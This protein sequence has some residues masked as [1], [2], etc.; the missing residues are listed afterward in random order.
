MLA[1]MN[2]TNQFLIAMPTLGDPNFAQTVTYVCAHSEEGAMGIVINRPL[3]LTLAELYQHMDLDGGGG[4]RADDP[5]LLGGPVETKRG[6]VVHEPV[7]EQIWD[8]VMQVEAGLAIAT[9]RDIL[10]AMA[11]GAGPTR[12][13][14]ALGYAGW[15]AGQLEGE[16]LDNAWLNGPARPDI[17]FECPY[18][19]RWRR[20]AESMGVDIDR[21]SGTA[22]H[23]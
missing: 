21:L 23:S 19:D 8:A 22:G 11:Q 6:F 16:V 14:V 17:I 12:S 9:S 3:D 20:A 5:V 2:L 4:E 10:E 1:A 18:P 15:G 13:L 7:E